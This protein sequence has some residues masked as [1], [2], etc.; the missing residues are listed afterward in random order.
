MRIRIVG[1]EERADGGL[2]VEF[3]GRAGTGRGR[4][5]S[6]DDAPVV[7][8]SYELDIT[9]AIELGGN[10]SLDDARSAPAVRCTPESCSFTA[11][12][13]AVDEDG[14]ATLRLS[15]DCIL[16]VESIQQLRVGGV[17]AIDVSVDAVA[18]T[19]FGRVGVVAP[20]AHHS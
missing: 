16:L 6:R 14:I 8:A 2:V 19:P 11:L 15:A 1:V 4:W 9:V 18:I 13:E 10:A 3:A 17:L 20:A 7:D 12:V 5:R